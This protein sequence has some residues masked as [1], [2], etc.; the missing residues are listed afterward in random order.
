[1]EYLIK[2]HFGDNLAV[3]RIVEGNEDK[4]VTLLNNCHSEIVNF[5]DE[6]G[7]TYRFRMDDVKF[8]TISKYTRA[9]ATSVKGYR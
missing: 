2:Y 9:T 8:T 7:V 1:M 3:G 6:N 5:E 4:D